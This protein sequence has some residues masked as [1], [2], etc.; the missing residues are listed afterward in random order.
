LLITA[1]HGNAEKMLDESTGQAHTAHTLNLVP[2]V[3]VGR[4]RGWR[5]ADRCRI[6]A[7]TLLTML[8]LPQPGG[9]DGAYAADVA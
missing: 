5:A 4:P 6:V 2:C 9:N 7:P 3:Y 8:G 1:D